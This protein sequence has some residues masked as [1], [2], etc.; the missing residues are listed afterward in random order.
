MDRT[1]CKIDGCE[2]SQCL[3]CK[4]KCFNAV[5][6]AELKQKCLNHISEEENQII[7]LENKI[8]RFENRPPFDV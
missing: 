2:N 7:K 3:R 4:K 5:E 6:T 1:I 8:K